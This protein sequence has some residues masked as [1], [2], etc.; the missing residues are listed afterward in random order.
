MADLQTNANRAAEGFN[1]SQAQLG[2]GYQRGQTDAA[3]GLERAGREKN[4]F[5]IDT[6]AS[7]FYQA[8]QAGW[9][10]PRRRRR[11]RGH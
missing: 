7:E 8:T 1:R 3:T 9:A 11:R 5:G 4:Q 2:L 10:P 6:R